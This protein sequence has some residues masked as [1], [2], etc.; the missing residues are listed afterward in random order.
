MVLTVDGVAQAARDGA[1]RYG[2]A[3]FL[4]GWVFAPS[5]GRLVWNGHSQ[6]L[7]DDE[8]A[9]LPLGLRTSKIALLKVVL[10]HVYQVGNALL[11]FFSWQRD[12]SSCLSFGSRTVFLCSGRGNRRSTC[13]SGIEMRPH[14]AFLA[15]GIESKVSERTT[16]NPCFCVPRKEVSSVRLIVVSLYHPPTDDTGLKLH[17]TMHVFVTNAHTTPGPLTT[18]GVIEVTPRTTFPP[19][20]FPPPLCEERKPPHGRTVEE[21]EEGE[22]GGKVSPGLTRCR[23]R[24]L[25]TIP[26]KCVEVPDSSI[27]G[28]TCSLPELSVICPSLDIA[29]VN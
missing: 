2:L 5:G 25:R 27:V 18:S 22:G 4:G 12:V 13:E 8:G 7:Q 6:R 29:R 19:I 1:R 11:F 17:E 21:R 9:H 3:D 23:A 26:S 24:D 14:R 20:S 15:S 28:P 10:F 16:L